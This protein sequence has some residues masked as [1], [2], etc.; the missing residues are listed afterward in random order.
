MKLRALNSK[1]QQYY[2]DNNMTGDAKPLN[3]FRPVQ[4]LNKRNVTQSP[5]YKITGTS[6][7]VNM[8]ASLVVSVVCFIA[9]FVYSL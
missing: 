8:N 9:T 3:R 7:S 4:M 2:T 5:E 1:E 6:S